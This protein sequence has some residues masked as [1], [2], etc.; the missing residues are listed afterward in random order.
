MTID[1]AKQI[2]RDEGFEPLDGACW[3][4]EQQIYASSV[5]T[6][7]GTFGHPA[8]EVQYRKHS[9]WL[10][11]TGRKPIQVCNKH[12]VTFSLGEHSAVAACPQCQLDTFLSTPDCEADWH[13]EKGPH[14]DLLACPMCGHS[15]I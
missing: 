1:Q 10:S 6:V 9:A 11:V 15:S 3:E 13:R 7:S 12:N 5:K 14:S 4:D 8:C 2:I